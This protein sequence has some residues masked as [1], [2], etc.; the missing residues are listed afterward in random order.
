MIHDVYIMELVGPLKARC[1]EP[2]KEVSYT[3]IPVSGE[4]S[5][6]PAVLQA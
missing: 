4:Q 5:P 3:G 6:L 2:L 1:S